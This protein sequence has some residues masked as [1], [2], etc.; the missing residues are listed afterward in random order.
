MIKSPAVYF[1]AF[2][3]CN[4]FAGLAANQVHAVSNLAHGFSFYADGRFA[5]Q[6]LQGQKCLSN[7]GE[8]QLL[9]LSNINLLVLLDCERRVSYNEA[10]VNKLHE[11]LAAGGTVLIASQH[12]NEQQN[13]LLQQFGVTY[14]ESAK[15]PLQVA[16]SPQGGG[17]EQNIEIQAKHASILQ[18][19][20]EKQWQT[21]ISD[22][23]DRPVV[24]LGKF[25]RGHILA[26]PRSLIGQ[27]NDGKDPINAGWL[28]ELLQKL[29]DNKPVDQDQPLPTLSSSN[30]GKR[31]KIGELEIHFTSYLQ[32]YYQAMQQISTQCLPLI[33]KRMGVP[34]SQGMGGKIGLLAT[35]GGG[36]SSG[37]FVG[38]AVFWEDFP[39]NKAGMVEFLTHEFVHSWVLPHQEVCNE[40]IATYVGNLVMQD[41]GHAEEGARRIEATIRRASSL[42]A[43][44][45]QYDL[46]GNPTSLHA[47]E[48][49]RAQKNEMHWGK[50]FWLWQQLENMQPGFVGDYFRTKRQL[51]PAKLPQAYGM[52]DFVAVVSVAMGKDMFEWFKQNGMPAP[53]EK[54]QFDWQ[55]A[56]QRVAARQAD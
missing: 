34:L 27:R 37:K 42:D 12:D 21:L 13:K 36:F 5:S 24:A 33:E 44:M 3:A 10:D 7:W 8:L 15:L 18:I 28:G 55:S 54:V 14:S 40:P 16:K 25:S 19:E 32:P 6:Y 35:D 52:S 9:D 23:Q 46:F 56:L 50:S 20:S 43:S 53:A 29:A 51:V 47:A 11:F 31:E 48:L 30:M 1:S 39:H 41:A 22:E 26:V 45:K 49:T 17:L 4:G 2:L 38:L